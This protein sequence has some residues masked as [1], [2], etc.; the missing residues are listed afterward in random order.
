MDLHGVERLLAALGR[1]PA[2]K[3][4]YIDCPHYC[5]AIPWSDPRKLHLSFLTSVASLLTVLIVP[6]HLS[7]RKQ[8][9]P[10]G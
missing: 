8:E 5:P 1:S 4:L 2:L 6:Q 9:R 10:S 3:E 7:T